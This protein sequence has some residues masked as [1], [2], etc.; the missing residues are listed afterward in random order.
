MPWKKEKYPPNWKSEIIPTIRERSGNCCEWCGLENGQTVY[1]VPFNLRNE[2]GYYTQQ[3]VWFR[4]YGDALRES[5][6][7][8][9]IQEARVVLT[10]AHLD[11]D[12]ENHDVSLERLAHLCQL[13]HLRYDAKEKFRRRNKNWKG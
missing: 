10:V 8:N 6:G 5:K 11:H 2:R 3:K 7:M 4:V 12:E 9:V 1:S 13:C